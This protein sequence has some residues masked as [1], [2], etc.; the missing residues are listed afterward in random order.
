LIHK[1]TSVRTGLKAELAEKIFTVLFASPEKLTTFA[2]PNRQTDNGFLKAKAFEE[3]LKA[4]ELPEAV[5]CLTSCATWAKQSARKFI[6]ESSCESRKKCRT[7]APR[8]DRRRKGLKSETE[9][10]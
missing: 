3:N 8:F 7:F 10:N 5:S 2:V 9:K 6:F 1:T 4:A